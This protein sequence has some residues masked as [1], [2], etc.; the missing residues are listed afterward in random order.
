VEFFDTVKCGKAVTFALKISLYAKVFQPVF[1]LQFGRR[2]I[3]TQTK[4]E[5]GFF[6]NDSD[7]VIF[8]QFSC[9]TFCNLLIIV[10]EKAITVY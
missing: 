2:S 3:Q 6:A 7:D 1:F 8:E 10:I 4:A 9:S 5:T